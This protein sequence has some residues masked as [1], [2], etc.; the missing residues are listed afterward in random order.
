M[1]KNHERYFRRNGIEPGRVSA[2]AGVVARN[3][4]DKKMVGRPMNPVV[5]EPPFHKMLED[6]A[7]RERG[8]VFNFG[9]FHL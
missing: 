1:G 7:K 3:V 8:V 2:P 5:E 9:Y 4:L 6:A